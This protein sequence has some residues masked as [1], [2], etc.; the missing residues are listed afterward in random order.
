MSCA[1]LALLRPSPTASIAR[2]TNAS[3]GGATQR[4]LK[5]SLAHLTT[6]ASTV[7]CNAPEIVG[8]RPLQP[9]VTILRG[10]YCLHKVHHATGGH[11]GSTLAHY[12]AI[13][14]GLTSI[15]GSSPL[16]S[17]AAIP[18]MTPANSY[19]WPENHARDSDTASLVT[20]CYHGC[21]KA[22]SV[23]RRSLFGRREHVPVITTR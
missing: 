19:L 2:R 5:G 18:P 16:A 20:H 9:A 4:W 22:G 6:I 1:T 21:P 15:D 12:R 14:N 3:R 8:R 11:R 7:N 13:A 10:R 17:S 23:F